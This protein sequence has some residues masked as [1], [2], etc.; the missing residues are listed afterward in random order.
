M[1][2][3][4]AVGGMDSVVVYYVTPDFQ[5]RHHHGHVWLAFQCH[6]ILHMPQLLIEIVF[7]HFLSLLDQTSY[8]DAKSVTSHSMLS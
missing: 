8:Q 7:Q 6:S 3:A 5:K 2:A 1:S 4:H